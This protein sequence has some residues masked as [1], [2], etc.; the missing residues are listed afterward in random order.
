MEKRILLFGIIALIL[1]GNAG[2]VFAEPGGY[3]VSIRAYPYVEWNNIKFDEYAETLNIMV[4][5]ISQWAYPINVKIIR[6][7]TTYDRIVKSGNGSFGMNT[8]LP[9]KGLPNLVSKQT[10]VQI[11]SWNGTIIGQVNIDTPSY[12][13]NQSR[14]SNLQ[15]IKREL[16][17]T[18][19]RLPNLDSLT[20][21]FIIKNMDEKSAYIGNVRIS[22][23][24]RTNKWTITKQDAIIGPDETITV[25]MSD[26]NITAFRD[27]D[28]KVQTYPLFPNLAPQKS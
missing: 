13:Y 26:I 7:N 22:N 11:I 18:N 4:D 17:P 16:R 9:Q 20:C 6:N 28:I 21:A 1:I 15:L 2:T 23:I 3:G 24:G 19:V 5:G 14:K 10:E 25:F 12:I 8:W 27:L